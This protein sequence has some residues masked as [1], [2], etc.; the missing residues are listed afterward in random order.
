MRSSLPPEPPLLLVLPVQIVW[1]G[2]RLVLCNQV[3]NHIPGVI[4]LGQVVLEHV[5]L[6][7]LVQER[8]PLPQLVVLVQ[9]PLEQGT[10]T[11]VVGQHQSRHSM[12]GLDVRTG[13]GQGHL[14]VGWT[15]RNKLCEF[16]L[17]DSLQRLVN[18]CGIH[19]SLDDVQDRDVDVMVG[20][21]RPSGHHHVLG[22]EESPHHIEDSR[23]A[24][25]GRLER[26]NK[27][28]FQ[29]CFAL[30]WFIVLTS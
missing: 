19:F 10:D 18:V 6:F 26:G 7:E 3:A 4:Q 23:F 11:R 27:Q 5:L 28:M 30:Q 2:S 22:L 14:E 1:P 21:I 17:P 9:T 20:L 25:T 16:L 15:P 24:D 12:I 13:S 8:A 29:L